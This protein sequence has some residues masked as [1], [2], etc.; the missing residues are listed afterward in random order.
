MHEK[1][2]PV[3]YVKDSLT[4]G[5]KGLGYIAHVFQ[6]SLG[7]GVIRRGSKKP[8]GQFIDFRI[9][10]TLRQGRLRVVCIGEGIGEAFFQERL[11]CWMR[12][13]AGGLVIGKERKAYCYRCMRRRE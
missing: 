11:I 13:V 8:T 5:C 10:G 9:Q 4:I 1:E 12:L 3:Y 7:D 6:A 2:T